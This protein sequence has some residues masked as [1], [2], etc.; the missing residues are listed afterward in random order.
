MDSKTCSFLGHRNTKLAQSQIQK[1]NEVLENLIVEQ[2][3][4]TFLF[5]SKSKFNNLCLSLVTSLKNKY[6]YIKRIGYTCR[7]ETCHLE[8]DRLEWEK[9]YLS[10]GNKPSQLFG[11]EMECEHRTKYTAGKASYIERNQAM[12]DNSNYC[13]F[14]YNSEYKPSIRKLSKKDM[15]YYQ[16]KSGTALA[17]KYAKK[18]KK[19]I[20]NIFNNFEE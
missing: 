12:I 4:S 18:K 20:I 7:S 15:G 16:P 19:V 8:K 6:P 17:Y 11:F 13:I 10:L 5:G 1:L 9:Y 3:V 14:Y 2:N